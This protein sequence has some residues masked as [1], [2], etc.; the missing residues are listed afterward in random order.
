MED[1]VK[2]TIDLD[3]PIYR[4]FKFKRFEGLCLTKL[5]KTLPNLK[6]GN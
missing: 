6:F 3:T 4:I 1:N 2:G 5:L